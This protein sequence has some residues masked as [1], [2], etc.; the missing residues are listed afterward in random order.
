VTRTSLAGESG[1]QAVAF[2]GE[3][4]VRHAAFGVALWFQAIEE[5]HFVC[6]FVLSH[7]GTS[8]L[9]F[10]EEFIKASQAGTV[11]VKLK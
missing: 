10:K 2:G 1:E 4:F 9:Q 5:E 7:D 3:F 11:E 8:R 6:A